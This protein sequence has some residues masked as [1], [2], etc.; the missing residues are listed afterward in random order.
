MLI[1]LYLLK[2]KQSYLYSKRVKYMDN[3]ELYIAL[4]LEE[5]QEQ[6][7]RMEQSLLKLEN[8]SD[9]SD[10]INTIFRMAHSLKGASA[11]VGLNPMSKL[12]HNLE[13]L[14]SE[15]RE[16]RI[17]ISSHTMEVFFKS[18]DILKEMYDT[19]RSGNEIQMDITEINNEIVNI[20]NTASVNP[21]KNKTAEVKAIQTD[22]SERSSEEDFDV[23]VIKT[24]VPE[25]L[26]QG[27]S[28]YRVSVE[29]SPEMQMKSIRAY[30]IASS[31][32]KVGEILIFSPSCY[33]SLSDEMFTKPFQ[34]LVATNEDRNV[35]YD[36]LDIV[37]QVD[38][39]VITKIEETGLKETQA[40]GTTNTQSSEKP[41][42]KSDAAR[43]PISTIRIDVGKMD[44]F[45]NLVS[46]FIINKESL[47]QI[48]MQLKRKYKNDLEVK[49]LLDILPHINFI[50]NELQD[51]VMSTRMLPLEHIFNRFPRMIRDLSIKCGKNVD[52]VIT[53]KETEI[54]R[55]IIEEL[56][57][58]LTH[59]LR[60][61][62][63]HG[64]ETEEE[65]ISSGKPKNGTLSLSARHE[66]SNIVIEV[67]DDGKGLDHD[68][69]REKAVEKGLTTAEAAMKMS[70]ES[71][72]NFIF[73]PGFSTAKEVTDVSGRGVGLDVVRSNIGKLHGIIDVKCEVGKG[74]SFVI[75]LPLTLAIIHALLVREGEHI[76]A[77]PINSII[78]SLRIKGNEAVDIFHYVGD[79]ELYD[80][81]DQALPVVRLNEYYRTGT[82][83]DINKFFIIIVG[84]SEKRMALVVNR[85][86]GEQEIVVKSIGDHIGARKL[87]GNLRGISGVSILGDGS[88]AQIV[89]IGAIGQSRLC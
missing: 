25:I 5:A 73:E 74:T 46:E 87:F 8:G 55:R 82:E 60:N 36:Y 79:K 27:R 62:V 38:K 14:L 61:S 16:N 11:M 45:M 42:I 47:N 12:A 15:V 3:Y 31:V 7:E 6:I 10:T 9:D 68:R 28:V 1:E 58:P 63:D 86:L 70:D 23:I 52:F 67:S 49:K 50:G 75:K 85:L 33:E 66:E 83:F 22:E 26:K 72:I 51:A 39:I 17:S 18:V 54:D 76:F 71:I 37:P 2:K 44:R 80:W 34:M 30:M 84:Y 41:S 56:I 4:F 53:G 77:I 35:L 59:I 69:I 19:V 64:I 57:D 65:R 89:D 81:R 13:N 48:G 40:A 88:I 21:A 24:A 29:F 32:A 43:S 20:I 78:E